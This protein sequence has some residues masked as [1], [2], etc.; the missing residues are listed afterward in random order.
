M[1][2]KLREKRQQRL[3]DE[4]GCTPKPWGGRLSVALVYPNT[5]YHAMSNLG[6]QAVYQLIQGRHD[7]LCER[8]FYPDLDDLEHHR[9]SGAAVV[10]FESGRSLN[11]FDIIALSLSFENDYINLPTLFDLARIVLCKEQRNEDSPLVIAGGICAFMNPEPIADY[12]DLFVVGEAEVLLPH[13]LDQLQIDGSHYEVLERLSQ[14]QG[15]YV[16]ARYQLTYGDDGTVT[17]I[18]PLANAC[19]PVQR[20]WVED[21]NT[22]RCQSLIKTPHTAFGSM[23]LIEVSRG[24]SRGCRFCAT[25]FVYLP[26]REKSAATVMTQ[27]QSALCS[28]C[29]AGLVGAAVSDYSSLDEVTAQ[30][31]ATGA[32]VSVASLRIDTMTRQQVQILRQLGQK[33]LSLAPEAGSQRLRDLINKHLSEEQILNAVTLLVEEGVLNLKLYF[34][35]GLPTEDSDDHEEL[36][37]LITKIR[38]IWLDVQRVKGHLGTITLS[39]NPFIPKPMTPFQWVGMAPVAQLKRTINMLRKR[40]NRLP[41]TK[42]QV[43]SLRSAQLQAVLARGDRRIAQILPALSEGA[44]LNAACREQGIDPKFYAQRQR[45][46]T[47]VLPWDV[48][49]G[50]VDKSY[51]WR[52]YQQGLAEALSPPCQKNCHR[53]GVCMP[54]KEN[55][56]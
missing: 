6:F 20:C 31:I 42:L 18:Q 26:P 52:E 1:P 49:D 37:A 33:T 15:Y 12:V 32:Q 4:T 45:Q 10:S 43:E 41:N 25:G 36:V 21:L 54:Q 23:D 53:C 30:V 44:N 8:V 24:C 17:A 40:I 27:L 50:G 34:L 19:F 2:R 38:Q 47:E 51:L 13:L 22:T 14:Q 39:V 3:A 16:P 56:T 29:T 48:I 7:C 11:S 5:Y 46:Q 35:I 55:I 28:D 9:K